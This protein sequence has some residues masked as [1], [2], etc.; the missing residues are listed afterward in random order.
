MDADRD[1]Q[2]ESDPIRITADERLDRCAQEPTNHRHDE[3]E[4]A[5]VKGQPKQRARTMD[6]FQRAGCETDRE[7]VHSHADGNEEDFKERHKVF[8][9]Y[10]IMRLDWE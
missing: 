6:G 2:N 3:L 1:Q 5:E 4:Q 8:G 10:L 9:L 7:G